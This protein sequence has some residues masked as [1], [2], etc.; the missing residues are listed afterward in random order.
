MGQIIGTRMEVYG[1]AILQLFSFHL[2]QL[3]SDKLHPILS[4]RIQGSDDN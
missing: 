3:E 4:T 1:D 2:L